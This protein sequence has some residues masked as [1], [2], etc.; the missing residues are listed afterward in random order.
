MAITE[1]SLIQFYV[2]LSKYFF[3]LVIY[4][5][6]VLQVSYSLISCHYLWLGTKQVPGTKS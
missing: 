2:R 1:S 3:L 5:E 4:L 6:N